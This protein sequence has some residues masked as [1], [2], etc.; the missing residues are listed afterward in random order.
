MS[1]H[2]E[3]ILLALA[4]VFFLF[5]GIEW[6]WLRRHPKLNH[7]LDASAPQKPWRDR[8]HHLSRRPDWTPNSD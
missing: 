8:L 5:I 7:A 2:P 1:F 4:P 6:V 3:L